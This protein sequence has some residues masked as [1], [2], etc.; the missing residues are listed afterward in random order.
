MTMGHYCFHP[1][2]TITFGIIGNQVGVHEIKWCQPKSKYQENELFYFKDL[3]EKLILDFNNL[4]KWICVNKPNYTLHLSYTDLHKTGGNSTAPNFFKMTKATLHV[5]EEKGSKDKSCRSRPRP[6]ILQ[7]IYLT[8]NSQTFK[9]K[10]NQL[11]GNL[12]ILEDF[13]MDPTAVV[14]WFYPF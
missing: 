8:G 5:L 2:D 1:F 3:R 9:M 13:I 4:G 11:L 7:I 6:M 10:R 12:L 14:G